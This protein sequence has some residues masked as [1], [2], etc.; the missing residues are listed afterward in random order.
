MNTMNTESKEMV[1]MSDMAKVDLIENLKNPDS[2]LFCSLQDDGTRKSKV[3]IYNAINNADER[4]SEHIGETLEII[5]VVA[6][7]VQLIDEQ[8][9][10]AVECLRTV[11]IDK[12]GTSYTATSAG[13]ANSLQRI[14]SLIGF[15]SW[16]DEPVKMKVKQVNTRNGNNKILTIELV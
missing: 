7:P 8:T 13:V 11:L 10:E 12:K 3:A 6:H 16:K 4:L 5:D 2:N 9:G 1:V 15:P 14:F